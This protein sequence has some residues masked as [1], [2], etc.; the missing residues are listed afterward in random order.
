VEAKTESVQQQWRRLAD[1]QWRNFRHVT[2]PSTAIPS[3]THLLAWSPE[4]E[5]VSK[6]FRTGRLERELQMEELSATMC[7]CIVILWVS[8]VSFVAHNP[9]YCFSTSVFCCKRIF[10]YRLSPETF[11]YTF[12][13]LLIRA[14]LSFHGATVA[15]CYCPLSRERRH[16][17]VDFPTDPPYG[18]SKVITTN[19]RKNCCFLFVWVAALSRLAF[20]KPLHHEYSKISTSCLPWD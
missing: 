13:V 14:A 8:L 3:V 15:S 10:R 12:V 2:T 20:H 11:G 4:Y 9:L 1:G 16:K 19:N 6:S 5:G 18:V 7:S 17:Y